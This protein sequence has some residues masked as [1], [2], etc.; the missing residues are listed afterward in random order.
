[1]LFFVNFKDLMLQILAFF[2]VFTI[3][4]LFFWSG[5]AQF[6]HNYIKIQLKFRA[7]QLLTQIGSNWF[8][9]VLKDWSFSGPSFSEIE[10]PG[11]IVWS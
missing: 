9:L 11:L 6:G 4:Y 10:G 1:M 5:F 8:K 7:T 2:V 3:F